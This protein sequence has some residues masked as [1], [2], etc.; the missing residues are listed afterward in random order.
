[1]EISNNLQGVQR[2]GGISADE[3]GGSQGNSSELLMVMARALQMLIQA[4]A[5]SGM[6]KSTN[7]GAD[8]ASADA[9]SEAKAPGAKLEQ[10]DTKDFLA[11]MQAMLEKLQTVGASEGSSAS[12]DSNGGSSHGGR[13][14]YRA[15]AILAA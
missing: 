1:M 6:G 10:F 14:G 3:P 15:L 2:S 12:G 11:H 7:G 5:A 13:R 8:E 9:P 4:F